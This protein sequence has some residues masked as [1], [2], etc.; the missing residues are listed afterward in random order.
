[1]LDEAHER[2]LQTDVLFGVVLRAMKARLKETEASVASA[3]ESKDEIIKRRLQQLAQ[4]L[5]LPPLKVIVMS[6][7]LDVETF[8]KFFPSAALIQIPGRQYPVQL[9]YTREP[10]DVR[11]SN[12]VA[13][14]YL[15]LSDTKVPCYCWRCRIM[16]MLLYVLPFK[17]TKRLKMVTF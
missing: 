5:M 3:T 17:S 13:L 1:V 2:S 16:W 6:A 4:K 9:L 10:Q 12:Q 14:R 8:Q 7:T 15:Y 11:Q